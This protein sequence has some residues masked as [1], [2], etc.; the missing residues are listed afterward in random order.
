MTWTNKIPR[1]T[2]ATLQRVECL[3]HAQ[4]AALQMLAQRVDAL[5]ALL[6]ADAS[7]GLKART[8]RDEGAA[9]AMAKA[10]AG[11]DELIRQCGLRAAEA[12]M[13]MTLYGRHAASASVTQVA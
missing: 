4:Q 10:G 5:S 7:H 12:E 6:A 11:I 1:E 8:R 2:L 3:Q 9:I 13:L